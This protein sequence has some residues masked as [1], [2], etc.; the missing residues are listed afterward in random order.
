MMKTRTRKTIAK[1]NL[2]Y[3]IQYFTSALYL[4]YFTLCLKEYHYDEKLIGILLMS[5]S[6][7]IILG[8]LFGFFFFKKHRKVLYPIF[9]TIQSIFLFLFVFIG[10]NTW[11]AFLCTFMIYFTSNS[12]LQLSDGLISQYEHKIDYPY[13]K[14]RFFGSVG[15]FMAI[16]LI[17][18]LPFISYS[19][20][21]I[22]SAINDVILIILF[23]SLSSSLNEEDK[24]QKGYLLNK[25]FIFYLVIYALVLGSYLA[26][27]SYLGSYF[28]ALNY[29]RSIY[30]YVLSFSLLI[31]MFTLL[32]L[33]LKKHK[34]KRMFLAIS[35]IVI[36]MRFLLFS[37]PIS[38]LIY[39]FIISSLRG[40]GWGMFLFSHMDY[41]KE[42]AKKNKTR[43]LFLLSVAQ[44]LLGA[45]F[46]FL[47]GYIL[48][49]YSI[50]FLVLGL[51]S[52]G[53]SF[54]FFIYQ[55]KLIHCQ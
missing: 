39:L 17:S 53:A 55:K 45:I 42:I 48:P 26:F 16:L 51:F 27:D 38:N 25:T 8:N 23:L 14:T 6:L 30:S 11:G 22:F 54:F 10:M 43:G 12:S 9:L 32:I 7:S 15:F 18:F 21:Y 19:L 46:H 1:I 2:L 13:T 33:N 50:Y 29:N 4:S 35:F 47:G 5:S 24:V 20:I 44:N 41:M 37:I 28:K 3:F 49:Y 31:E 40:I 36:S 52:F 34:N